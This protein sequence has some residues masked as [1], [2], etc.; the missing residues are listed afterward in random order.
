MSQQTLPKTLF[1]ETQR[2]SLVRISSQEQIEHSSEQ[3]S[4][5]Q[6]H[7]E[8]SSQNESSSKTRKLWK[9]LEEFDPF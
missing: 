2:H 4:N 8:T 7:A 1:T 5:C 6:V 9:N 3:A